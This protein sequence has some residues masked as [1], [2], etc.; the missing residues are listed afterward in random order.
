MNTKE[1]YQEINSKHPLLV[2]N[3]LN[4]S[5]MESESE[6]QT[7]YG[8]LMDWMRDY[9]TNIP[10]TDRDEVI[11]MLLGDYVIHHIFC[12]QK[13]FVVIQESNVDGEIIINATP[14][15]TLE[16]ARKVM[17]DEVITILR[18]SHHFGWCKSVKTAEENY[19]VERTNTSF[20]INDP[21]DDYHEDIKIEEKVIL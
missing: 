9:Y 8:D 10:L 7:I 3:I 1:I 6:R 16:S 12:L 13:V 21:C 4:R 14:C 5:S 20:Y 17:C 11:K 2:E 18:E 15:R 19:E